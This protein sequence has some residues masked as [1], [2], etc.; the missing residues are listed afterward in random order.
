MEGFLPSVFLMELTKNRGM[1]MK[2]DSRISAGALALG[3]FAVGA[4]S[5]QAN[6]LEW[7]NTLG[8]NDFSNTN[9]WTLLNTSGYDFRNISMTNENRAIISS[10]TNVVSDIR[11]G[12]YGNG[13]LEITGGYVQ[14]ERGN[15]DTR[16]G[17]NGYDGT[18]NMS[19]GFWDI[20]QDFAVGLASGSSAVFN[21]SGGQIQN[22]RGKFTVGEGG[23]TGLFSISG[24]AFQ[25]RSYAQIYDQ[26]TFEVIGGSATN[27]GIGSYD[28]SDGAWIQDAGGTLKIQVDANGVTPIYV[29]DTGSGDYFG[30]VELAD[31]ALLDVSF[32]DGYTATGT[33]TI[34][35]FDG[36][37]INLGL[38]F[39][40][41]V[42]SGWD[43]G[44]ESNKLVVSY[45]EDAPELPVVTTPLM[46][47]TFYALPDSNN[48]VSVYWTAPE[49]VSLGYNVYRSLDDSTYA[50]IATG[51]VDATY[52]DTDVTNGVTYYYK[53][54]GV[55]ESGEGELT[56][57]DPARPT[58]YLIIGTDNTYKSGKTITKHQ[59][60]DGDIDTYFDASDTA[61]SWAG[62]DFG[63]G[64]EQLLLEARYTIRGGWASAYERSIGVTIQ[65]ANSAD[66]IDAV[67]LH[68]VTTNAVN[69]PD[70][71]VVVISNTTP[72][73]YVR[74]L[75]PTNYPLYSIAEAS[76]YVAD[77][78]TAE[79]TLKTWLENYGLV[80]GEDYAT[81][82]AGDTD[83]DGLVAWEEYAAG[84][85]PTNAASVLEL[86]AIEHS[87]NGFVLSW[88]SVEG[89]SYSIVARSALVGTSSDILASNITGVATE[90]SYTV[91]N[92][93]GATGFFEVTV[94]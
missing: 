28:S 68:T 85:V 94:E 92:A 84:T 91:T 15:G 48:L 13:E 29:A 43:V 25:T 10:G 2:T 83:G 57:S 88:Q 71:N 39:S 81:A 51:V 58:P 86:N 6:E 89:K 17:L 18:V 73:R 23:S 40:T 27:I 4:M 52:V 37:F 64:N 14:C 30:N 19:G 63:E 59:L 11:V 41:N 3:M 31:G 54:S 12:I 90:T 49:G 50:Q 80:S 61:T 46:P 53:V 9:N 26:G 82:D 60:F 55:N 5:A 65:G 78:F 67:T 70:E 33:W 47:T 77:D 32:V 66:F 72:F 21:M 34:M 44:V 1:N 45:G 24:G 74:V 75:A 22:G 38:A 16:L 62:L 56:D 93:T 69:Y 42:A 35:E 7:A 87:T 36:S 79:G 8:D 20:G 76:F